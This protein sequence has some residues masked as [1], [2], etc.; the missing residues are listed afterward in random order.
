[1]TLESKGEKMKKIFIV[2]TIIC[3]LFLIGN[4]YATED[5]SKEYAKKTVEDLKAIFTALDNN[6][7]MGSLNFIQK[8]KLYY[9]YTKMTDEETQKYEETVKKGVYTE[10]QGTLVT[11]YKT[12]TENFMKENGELNVPT[13]WKKLENNKFVFQNLEAGKGYFVEIFVVV[14]Y[15]GK[16]S[17]DSMNAIYKAKDATTLE[18]LSDTN[19]ALDYMLALIDSIYSESEEE[20]KTST[21]TNKTNTKSV[22]NENTTKTEKDIQ[23]TVNPETGLNE[24]IKYVVPLALLL[25]T[26]LVI[27][28]K[29]LVH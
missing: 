12:N 6:K 24:Y 9:K 29:K 28:K 25:G 4:V 15:N 1:M 13:D 19:E 27:K 26:V 11:K 22:S 5:Q 20:N 2:F 10:E 17:A 7:E 18:P 14:E 23:T 21:E 8:D 16:T 3:S